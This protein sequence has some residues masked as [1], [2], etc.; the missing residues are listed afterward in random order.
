MNF[1]FNEKMAG[2]ENVK[3]HTMLYCQLPKFLL[4]I[5]IDKIKKLIVLFDLQS[6]T[7]NKPH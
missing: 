4:A 5:L 6:F 1:K 3:S 2:H 7:F